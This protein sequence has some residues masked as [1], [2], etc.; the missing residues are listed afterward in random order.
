MTAPSLIAD[1]LRR[2]GRQY[3][4]WQRTTAERLR[5]SLAAPKR[6]FAVFAAL[7]GSAFGAAAAAL[8]FA[9]PTLFHEPP[10]GWEVVTIPGPDIAE[11]LEV[12]AEATDIRPLHHSARPGETLLSLLC[13][14]GVKDP[15]AYAFIR[16]RP[17]L[18]ALVMPQEGQYF[19][20]G[21][22]SDGRLA[23]LRL[24]MEGPHAHD[25]RTIEVMRAGDILMAST[26]PFAF[27][28]EEVLASGTAEKTLWS[29]YRK[30]KLPEEV[31]DEL[32]AV[33]DGA[34]NPVTEL[35]SGDTLRVVYE[36]KLAEGRFIRTGQ[37][38]A[39]Q[40][41]RRDGTVDEAFRFGSGIQAESFYTLDGR[42][43]SQTFMR[44]PLEVKDV[45]SE[46]AP[47]RRHPITG[48]LRAHNGTDLR[49]PTGARIYAAADGVVER[50]AYERR[51]YGHYVKINHGLGRTTLYAHM[52]KV[53]RGIRPGR[54]V[55]KGE[56][57]GLVGMTGLAT[58][59]HLHYELMIDGVQINPKT[60]DLPDT[61]N[62]TAFQTAQLRAQA[63]AYIRTFEEAARREGKPSPK[64]LLAEA[65][66]EAERE[67]QAKPA[68][69]AKT[70]SGEVR[71]T[72]GDS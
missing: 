64:A 34:R 5:V 9:S 10:A 62:L 16:S 24:Y 45:S 53:T 56:V 11:K 49:A 29:T 61:E 65:A 48:E 26:L 46:F 18:R 37:L 57:I 40:I 1:H 70:A 4:Y 8:G 68:G 27:E 31:V 54:F 58:G 28:T 35:K 33:W 42:S 47:L 63:A 14:F 32:E 12:L 44:I 19:T 67:A 36:K 55:R 22:L 41:V 6:R 59:P 66:R 50:V 38:L 71:R 2:I 23:Y 72:G 7:C 30:L 25:S 15:Q 52:S 39:V 3:L 17:E 13:A 20:A 69:G 60:A 51:G 43:A 21:L